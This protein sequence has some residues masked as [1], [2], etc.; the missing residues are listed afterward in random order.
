MNYQVKLVHNSNYMAKQPK[1][2]ALFT[3]KRN[4]IN[5]LFYPFEFR[6]KRK[7]HFRRKT[8]LKRGIIVGFI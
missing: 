8:I 1:T 4:I 5:K 2:I 7:S 6:T 3:H